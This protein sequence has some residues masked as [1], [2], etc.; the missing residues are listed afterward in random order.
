MLM[1]VADVMSTVIT[2]FVI[3]AIL[4]ATGA[5]VAAAVLGRT[6][7]TKAGDIS[8]DL[9]QSRVTQYRRRK[10]GHS[11]STLAHHFMD[12]AALALNIGSVSRALTVAAMA[13]GAILLEGGAAGAGA[14]ESDDAG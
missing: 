4:T 10:C 11:I 13:G 9:T 5:F 7:L 6:R 8:C 1:P 2:V 14:G 3:A 12:V